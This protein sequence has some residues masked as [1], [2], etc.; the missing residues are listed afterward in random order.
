MV[1]VLAERKPDLLPQPTP[2]PS[3]S[4]SL[5]DVQVHSPTTLVSP[6]YRYELSLSLM[7]HYV[8]LLVITG[9]TGE[10]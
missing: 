4:V 5:V 8:S 1:R 7:S 3:H 6:S 2:P 9:V 10:V